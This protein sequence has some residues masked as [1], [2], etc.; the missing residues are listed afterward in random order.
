MTECSKPCDR[1][2][3]AAF[4]VALKKLHVSPAEHATMQGY[5]GDST[6]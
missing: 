5:Y 2:E 3:R 1:A 4:A 6:H